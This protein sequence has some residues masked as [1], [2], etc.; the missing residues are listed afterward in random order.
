[1][2]DINPDA[3]NLPKGYFWVFWCEKLKALN[4]YEGFLVKVVAMMNLKMENRRNRLVKCLMDR[5]VSR[6]E[7]LLF[8]LHAFLCEM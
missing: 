8:C 7:L 4:F 6:S 5:C 3:T 2:C 1:M